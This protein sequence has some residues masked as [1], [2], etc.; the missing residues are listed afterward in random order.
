MRKLPESALSV[1]DRADLKETEGVTGTY[2]PAS[3]F[4]L[5]VGA[6]LTECPR[7]WCKARDEWLVDFWKKPGNDLL[8][9][10]ISTL[11]AKI[12]ATSWYVEG[13]LSIALAY[14]D[15]FLNR[16][17]FGEGWDPFVIKWVQGY[18]DRDMGGLGERLRTSKEDVTGAALGFAHLDESKCYLTGN[19]EYPIAYGGKGELRRLHRSQVMRIV[20][21]ESGRERDQ[22]A[23][24]CSTSRAVAT[25][26]ILLDV[27]RY[28]RERL[29]DLPPA[30]I[31]FINNMS[32]TQWEDIEKKYSAKQRNEG[33]TTWRDVMVALGIDPAY[34]IS[35]ELFELSRLPEHYDERVA[36]EVAIYTFALA[37]RVDPREYWPVSAGP[38]GTATEA[39]IQHKKAKAKGEGIIFQA[40]ERQ[41][42]SPLSVPVGVSFRFDYRDDEEDMVAA[43]IKG[44]QITNIRRM[45]EPHPSSPEGGGMITT[46]EARMLLVREKLILPEFVSGMVLETEKVYDIKQFGPYVRAYR[47]G[48]CLFTGTPSARVVSTQT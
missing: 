37:F 19:P 23:G 22:G 48:Q 32:D 18:L 3:A 39:E 41:L 24:F 7:Y 15:I 43:Q 35:A 46:E 36:T 33:N 5:T 38:L 8:A 11:V 20:D 34:P 10:A 4:I 17:D 13:P 12:A 31:L 9:G 42:N 44:Q 1:Q 26:S 14:R 27:V 40:M 16:I 28:K 47:D 45:W 25:A 30:G 2:I 29:S 21:M 6:S